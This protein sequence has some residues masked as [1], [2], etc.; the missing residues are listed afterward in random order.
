M[1]TSPGGE[2]GSGFGS[3]GV[4]FHLLAIPRFVL[5]KDSKQVA[6]SAILEGKSAGSSAVVDTCYIR[7]S[8]HNR[9]DEQSHTESTP[10][11]RKDSQWTESLDRGTRPLIL[12]HADALHS[13]R[14]E[15]VTTV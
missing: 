5:S 6:I 3:L 9:Q 4:G 15:F 12:P 1:T 14:R 10:Y 8:K 7:I 13:I 11:E 2:C